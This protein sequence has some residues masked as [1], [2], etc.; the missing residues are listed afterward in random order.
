MV[1]WRC[2]RFC[3]PRTCLKGVL[4]VEAKLCYFVFETVMPDRIKGLDAVL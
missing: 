3:Y 2:K 4:D 1:S